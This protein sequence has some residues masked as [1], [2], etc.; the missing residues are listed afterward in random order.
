MDKTLTTLCSSSLS[1][2]EAPSVEKWQGNRKKREKTE[3]L[4][5]QGCTGD[6][7][8]GQRGGSLC[9]IMPQNCTKHG[10]GLSPFLIPPQCPPH[11][12]VS[13]LPSSRALHFPSPHPPANQKDETDLWGGER[14]SSR[15]YP[16]PPTED[17]WKFRGEG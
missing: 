6:D 9:H 16:Y 8:K 10:R 11:V 12:F 14:C 13:L 2:A 1:S 5:N 17:H 3:K 7:K 15:K 4:K